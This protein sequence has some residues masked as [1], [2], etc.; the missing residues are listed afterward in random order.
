MGRKPL[1]KRDR[2]TDK[3][4]RI[5]LTDAERRTLERAARRAKLRTSTWA[6]SVLLRE[7]TPHEV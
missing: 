1:K 6:R 7:A 3:P 5:R 2:R 4:L